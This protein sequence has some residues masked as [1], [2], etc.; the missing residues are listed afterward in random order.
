MIEL[1]QWLIGGTDL[2]KVVIALDPF[3][4]AALVSTAGSIIGGLAS[5]Q[6]SI[7]RTAEDRYFEDAVAKWREVGKFRDSAISMASA[8]S[9][10]P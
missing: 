2:T 5:Q 7:P 4:I 6:P 1:I 10:K 9:G 3:V 8:L